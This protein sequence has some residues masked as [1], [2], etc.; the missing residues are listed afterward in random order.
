MTPVEIKTALAD[1]CAEGSKNAYIS[2][3]IAVSGTR[4]DSEVVASFY[5]DDLTGG[6][7]ISA[8]GEGFEEAIARLRVKWDTAKDLADKKIIRKMALAIIEVTGDQGECSDAALRGAGF[9]QPQI[10]RI[11]FLA[12]AEAT[13]LA[14]RGPFSIVSTVGANEGAA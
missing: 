5:P 13:R 3:S 4:D 7:C 11:G 2:V 9:H 8:R 12:C 6:H 10:D 14:A 1:I